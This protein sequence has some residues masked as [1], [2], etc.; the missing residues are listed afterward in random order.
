MKS[1]GW[2]MDKEDI[3]MDMIYEFANYL[4]KTNYYR[5]Q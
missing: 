4:A 3:E 2:K 1:S 5:E